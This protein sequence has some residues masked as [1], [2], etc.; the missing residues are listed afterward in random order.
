MDNFTEGDTT[1]V[2]T[3]LG[4]VVPE[5]LVTPSLPAAPVIA[6]VSILGVTTAIGNLLIL[7]PICRPRNKELLWTPTNFLIGNLAFLD[8]LVGVFGCPPLVLQLYGIPRDFRWCLFIY[9]LGLSVSVVAIMSY[10]TIAAERLVAIKYPFAKVRILT[11]RN[12]GLST[13][14][15]WLM[16]CIYGFIP[17]FGWNQGWNE[18]HFCAFHMVIELD[19]IVYITHFLVLLPS[20]LVIIVAYVNI[21]VIAK[22]HAHQIAEATVPAPEDPPQAPFTSSDIRLAGKCFVI[23]VVYVICHFPTMLI[24]S[25]ALFFGQPC[26]T[27]QII[28]VWLIILNS[29]INPILYANSNRDL[30]Y[31][32]AK[33]LRTLFH[34]GRCSSVAPIAQE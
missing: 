17:M 1:A 27:C 20:L 31:A 26:P 4:S 8:F 18:Q 19:Y 10:A 34:A 7:I 14:L 15:C 2:P 24:N 32:V 9:C 6:V 25:V 3:D 13:G 28:M 33:E 22:R 12:I 30:K 29:T 11:M 21:Y 5:S 16:G 23:I